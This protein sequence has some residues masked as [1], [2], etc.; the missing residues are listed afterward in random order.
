MEDTTTT[1]PGSKPES[2]AATATAARAVP[3]VRAMDTCSG[4]SSTSTSGSSR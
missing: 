1:R 3:T 2:A 4:V